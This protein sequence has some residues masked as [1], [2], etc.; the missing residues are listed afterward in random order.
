ISTRTVD[1]I[2]DKGFLTP[3]EP[4]IHAVFINLPTL[5]AKIKDSKIN[6]LQALAFF[7]TRP[8]AANSY[9]FLQRGISH[10]IARFCN[11]FMHPDLL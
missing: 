3:R 4:R 7:P 8:Y 6:H 1:N 2:V 11:R 9:K 10:K 5:K